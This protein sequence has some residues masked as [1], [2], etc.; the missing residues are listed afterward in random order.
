MLEF[1][2]SKRCSG[3][4]GAGSSVMCE[5]KGW[6]P[7]DGGNAIESVGMAQGV[8]PGLRCAVGS[9]FGNSGAW[10]CKRIVLNKFL[11][12]K[13]MSRPKKVF[14]LSFSEGQ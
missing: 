11:R 14:A 5:T 13:A 6:D 10:V 3:I 12:P 1:P 8:H 9:C 7:E 2:R 4:P